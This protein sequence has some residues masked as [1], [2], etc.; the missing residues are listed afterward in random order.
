MLLS[1]IPTGLLALALTAALTGLVPSTATTA[2]A[3][4]TVAQSA[5][6]AS[7]AHSSDT[8][9]VGDGTLSG[10][11][12][13]AIEGTVV[14]SVV[15]SVPSPRREYRIATSTGDLVEITAEFAPGVRTGGAFAGNLAV[16]KAV[17]EK[18][19]QKFAERILRSAQAPVELDSGAGGSILDVLEDVPVALAVVDATVEVRVAAAVTPKA[20]T[21]DVA[22]VGGLAFSDAQV[23]SL[24]ARF[25]QYWPSQSV[26]I[27]SSVSR[28]LGIKR[29]SGAGVGPCDEWGQ[30]S[31]GAAQFGLQPADYWSSNSGRH[32]LILSGNDCGWSGVATIGFGVHEGGVIYA[33]PDIHT[34]AHEFGHNLSLD[35]SNVHRC[36]SPTRVEGTPEQGCNDY[37]YD[38]YYDIMGGGYSYCI[39]TDCTSNDDDLTALNVTHKKTLGFLPAASVAR[40]T[41]TGSRALGPASASSGLRAL[42]VVDQITGD[43]YLVEYRSGTGIEAGAFYTVAPEQVGL[44]VGV[45]VLKQR[46]PPPEYPY[47]PLTSVVFEPVLQPGDSERHLRLDTGQ[48]FTT[49]SGGLNVTVAAMSSEAATVAVTIAPLPSTIDRIYGADR[50]STAIAISR[51]GFPT[52]APVVY[53]TQGGNYPDALAAAPAAVRQGG[54]LLLTPSN[55]LL[56]AVKQRII[57]LKP[58]RIV[59][60]GGVGAIGQS[61]FSELQT[62]APTQRIGGTDR[63][64][65]G[66]KIVESAFP[67]ASVAYI[68]TGRGFPDALS[69]A[70]AGGALGIPV[71]LVDGGRTTLDDATRA[72]LV[73]LGVTTTRIAGGTAAVSAGIEKSLASFTTVTRSAG[74]DRF[75]TSQRLNA[76]AFPSLDRVFLATGYQFPDAL[77][78][79]ALAGAEGSPLYVIPTTCVPAATRSD[80]IRKGASHVTLLGGPAALTNAVLGLPRC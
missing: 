4:L 80:I 66:R 49:P 17:V 53:V 12:Q 50:Y 75:S 18:V 61:V 43:T 71:I 69:A 20:H 39:N 26:G 65:T 64:D 14:V 27:I 47:E 52:T 76:E 59:V 31:A 36:D 25:T 40:L 23:A 55:T 21:L 24:V 57:E 22:I 29:Y 38:D 48:S 51:A 45:R 54:P 37:N 67:T 1:K 6:P 72:L 42:E 28:P 74:A 11:P 77:A 63:F 5:V 68:A 16:P 10:E 62:I 15:D 44:G 46:T 56:A 35:H 32:L 30:W 8:I 58:S 19:E 2:A 13:L 3:A 70:A 79:A 34:V 60:V 41:A 73:R 33:N 7:A 9:E 78:G